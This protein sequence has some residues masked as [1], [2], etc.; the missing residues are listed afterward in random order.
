MTISTE[1][2]TYLD[3]RQGVTTQQ[4][5]QAGVDANV[6]TSS[7]PLQK[8]T[9]HNHNVPANI[10]TRVKQLSLNNGSG[11]DVK[12]NTLHP[13][14]YGVGKN[15]VKKSTKTIVNPPTTLPTTL[16]K[17]KSTKKILPTTTPIKLTTKKTSTTTE[18]TTVQGDII[19]SRLRDFTTQQ[20]IVKQVKLT[21][22][23]DVDK[24]Y[25]NKPNKSRLTITSI[26]STYGQTNGSN[27]LTPKITKSISLTSIYTKQPEQGVTGDVTNTS[28]P[29]TSYDYTTHSTETTQI[30]T[31]TISLDITEDKVVKDALNTTAVMGVKIYIL[32]KTTH[33]EHIL[34]TSKYVFF[35]TPS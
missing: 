31:D 12:H 15:D 28:L 35:Y 24:H 1:S 29:I 7:R 26:M 30:T 33:N 3:V 25:E 10:T 5:P 27:D 6:S 14:T 17:V 2:S 4:V 20:Y 9:F 19:T 22:L 16:L 21:T 8:Q 23:Y 13:V 34:F 11:V 32:Q 18:S